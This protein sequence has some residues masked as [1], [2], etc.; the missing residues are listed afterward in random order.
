MSSELERLYE[1]HDEIDKKA[2]RWNRVL[3]VGD[4][5][6]VAAGGT[7][8]VVVSADGRISKITIHEGWRDTTS[9]EELG[10]RIL[11]AYTDATTA[12][13][14]DWGEAFDDD[15]EEDDP[16]PT[17][18][19]PLADSFAEAMDRHVTEAGPELAERTFNRL[20]ELLQEVVDKLDEAEEII[21]ERLTAEYEGADGADTVC[22]TLQGTGA[23]VDVD[24]DPDWLVSRHAANITKRVSQALIAARRKVSDAVPD[25]IMAGTPLARVYELLA[26]PDALIYEL[27]H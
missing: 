9:N 24:I 8:E 11:E 19:P 2:Q 4:F 26:D 13:M 21:K 16:E 5:R 14:Q 17:P 20:A 15:E 27:S 18:I 6:G 7:V 23:L 22:V 1:L 3:P 25:D 10:A 12:V